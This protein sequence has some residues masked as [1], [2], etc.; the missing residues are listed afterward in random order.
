MA[1]DLDGCAPSHFVVLQVVPLS[2][3]GVIQA[4]ATHGLPIHWYSAGALL[5]CK[6]QHVP[7]LPVNGLVLP[8]LGC[9]CGNVQHMFNVTAY[10]TS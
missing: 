5:E 9:H 1:D 10:V 7:K 4:H 2:T 8:P 6:L 3:G